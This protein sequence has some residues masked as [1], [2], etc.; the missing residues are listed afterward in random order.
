MRLMN[1]NQLRPILTLFV[2]HTSVHS[3]PCSQGAEHDVDVPVSADG[4]RCRM[5]VAATI[6]Q[7]LCSAQGSREAG[8]GAVLGVIYGESEK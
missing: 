7:P 6:P 2:I 8:K 5:S 1:T 4:I 3:I